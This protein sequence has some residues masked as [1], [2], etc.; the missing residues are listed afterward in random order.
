MNVN[1]KPSVAQGKSLRFGKS[2]DG[3]K[4]LLRPIQNPPLFW[5]TTIT[6]PYEIADSTLAINYSRS[7]TQAVLEGGFIE[8]YRHPGCGSCA[9]LI[10][11][12]SL[13]KFVFTYQAAQYTKDFSTNITVDNWTR[14][15]DGAII[16]LLSNGE[17]VSI[18]PQN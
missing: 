8:Y 18:L 13:N 11:S 2:N 16:N 3:K 12:F 4:T 15:S 9:Q 7:R 14:V 6:G 1:F 10:Y 17:I 5:Q